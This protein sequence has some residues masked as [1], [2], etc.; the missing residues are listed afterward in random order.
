M[1]SLIASIAKIIDGEFL[2]IIAG[3]D[4]GQIIKSVFRLFLCGTGRTD[5]LVVDDKPT[6][7]KW[8]NSHRVPP[9]EMMTIS[10]EMIG[11]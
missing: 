6:N 9:K 5:I 2:E 1:Y 8:A 10:G 4:L 7:L 3:N 11:H